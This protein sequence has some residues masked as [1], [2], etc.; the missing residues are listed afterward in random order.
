VA[1][2]TGTI[3]LQPGELA[4]REFVVPGQIKTGEYTL[5][6]SAKNLETAKNFKEISPVSI[7]GLS[8]SLNSRTLKDIYLDPESV[9]GQSA[10]TFGSNGNGIANGVLQAKIIRY[11]ESKGLEEEAPGAFI[12]YN[13]IEKGY[14][15]GNLL[16]LVTDQG[17]LSYDA[18]S[19]DVK[20]L[21]SFD[22]NPGFNSNNL[23]LSTAGELWI[24]STAGIW[25]Q[26][27]S[28]QWEHY[29]TANGLLNNYIYN[30]I[31]VNGTSG[32]ET[33]AATS[34]GISVH[35]SGQW[36]N[37]TTVNGLPANRT[38]RLAVDG[39]GTVW[40][41]T[42]GGVVKFNGASF[43]PVGAPFGS[44][45]VSGYM[46]A[47][48]DGSMWLAAGGQ[49]YRYQPAGHQWNQWNLLDLYPVPFLSINIWDMGTVNGELWL[50]TRLRDG[51][52]H[53][54]NGLLGYNGSFIT[55]TETEAPGLFGL[56]ASCIIP[57]NSE[58]DTVY[59]T[60]ELGF[61]AFDT[62]TWQHRVMEIDSHKLPGTIYSMVN[63]KNGNLWAGTRYGLSRYDVHTQQW[64]NYCS[65]PGNELLMDVMRVDTDG[66]NSV[67]GYTPY[68]YPWGGIIRI[69][70]DNGNVEAM[71]FSSNDIQETPYSDNH[72]AV[73]TQ[74]R[75]WFGGY[76][77][78]YYYGAGEWRE[79]P[80]VNLIRCMS[81]DFSGGI[82]L[83]AGIYQGDS[84]HFHL[85]HIK[86][87]FT[88]D[89]YTSA[90]SGLIPWEK[91]R[92]YLDQEGI[93]WIKH[94]AYNYNDVRSLQSFDGSNWI[95]YSNY[96]GF[97]Q[98]GVM[99]MVKDDT[100]K[101]WVLDIDGN[102]YSLENHQ[103]LVRR[104]GIFYA[105]S[106]VFSNGKLYSA[107]S[108]YGYSFSPTNF[109]K[110]SSA[111]GLIEEELWSQNYHVNLGSA[112]T[113]QV[114]LLTGKTFPPGAYELKTALLS[115]LNQELAASG[116]GFAVKDSGLS[117]SLI[118]N[119]SPCG[120]LKPG[121]DLGITV[122]ALN[123]T[124]ETKSNLNFIVKK[125]SA[126]GAEEVLLS[127]TLHLDPG[128][129]EAYALDFNESTTGIW[130]LAAFLND[131]ATGE[132][133]E[134]SLLIGVTAPEV[135]LAVQ[136]PEYA[137][138]ESY[139]VQIHLVNEGNIIA[140]AQL[141][142]QAS[143]DG[144]SETPIAETII[145]APQDERMFTVNDTLTANKDK[146]YY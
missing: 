45:S 75:I 25:K 20:V 126:D 82:W 10:I 46:T 60:C 17:V 136:A 66:Q 95:D 62:G 86:N 52:D 103:F 91:D 22:T 59:F 106:L 53:L 68:L 128:Q 5:V 16:Y 9:S 19:G 90:N 127:N 142:V 113:E 108:R 133:K 37:Y 145:L 110:I 71:P 69:D 3:P 88:I 100:G 137:G 23:F 49:L 139:E 43:E 115:P 13:M 105:D 130:Q 111:E 141:T 31:E 30:I 132:E 64:T 104:E 11:A 116:Y 65:T 18:V 117:V 140:A 144:S 129:S 28:G 101:L 99:N 35:R 89:D 85:L 47:T 6:Q 39:S 38:Y 76:T 122:E 63:D 74:G 107:G 114:D 61:M 87:D 55:Y 135:S 112:G 77:H 54:V 118:A 21:Y 125:I 15:S 97:P 84:S 26:N 57:G 51:G 109:L 32:P 7:A 42:S 80:D 96:E 1:E 81:K 44:A 138:D 70:L 14:S 8:V 41:S 40:A 93:L 102:L 120:F 143:G 12:P 50:R 56:N 29:T 119:C 134:S 123:N 36:V 2:F 72:M 33:W 98:P 34:A 83:G 24:A 121:T 73:D 4:E 146:T 48:A 94:Y 67:Y 27:R 131:A 92:L 58:G 78:L 124:P 79:G